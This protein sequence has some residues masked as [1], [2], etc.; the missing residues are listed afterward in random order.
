MTSSVREIVGRTH[1][2]RAQRE[3]PGADRKVW[4][5]SG[6]E[7]MLA[8]ADKASF[9]KEEHIQEFHCVKSQVLLNPVREP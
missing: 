8:E 6:A 1:R 7:E 3:V 9:G 4:W 2:S 5:S